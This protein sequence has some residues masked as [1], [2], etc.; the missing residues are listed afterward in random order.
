MALASLD[1]PS[2]WLQALKFFISMCDA[3]GNGKFGN[4]S[5]LRFF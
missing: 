1:D 3:Y 5:T 4:Y 2:M